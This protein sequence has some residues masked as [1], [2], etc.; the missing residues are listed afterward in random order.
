MRQALCCRKIA[1]DSV[2]EEQAWLAGRCP[3]FLSRA[4]PRASTRPQFCLIGLCDVLFVKPL[5]SLCY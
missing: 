4:R 1:S 5:L 2:F 3:I